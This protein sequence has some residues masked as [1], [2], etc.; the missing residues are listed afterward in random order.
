M[1][2]SWN[3][4]DD[5]VEKYDNNNDQAALFTAQCQRFNGLGL[6][7][8]RNQIDMELVYQFAYAPIVALWNKFNEII[9]RQREIRNRY[10]ELAGLEYLY[11]EIVKM[12]KNNPTNTNNR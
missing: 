11:N 7:A 9:L 12:D 5:F 2:W 1:S 3:D 8:M 6:L 10:S 4:Y